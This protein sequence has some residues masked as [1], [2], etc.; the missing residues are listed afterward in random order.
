MGS[1]ISCLIILLHVPHNYHPTTTG[2]AS[3]HNLFF[4]FLF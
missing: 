1:E 3:L 2:K 4:L